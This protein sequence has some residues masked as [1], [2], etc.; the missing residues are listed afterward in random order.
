MPCTLAGLIHRGEVEVVSDPYYAVSERVDLPVWTRPCLSFS[1]TSATV[2]PRSGRQ[3][4]PRAEGL[5][6]ESAF[7][8]NRGFR[9]QSRRL[10]SNG[11]APRRTCAA[12]PGGLEERPLVARC[13]PVE[14]RAVDEKIPVSEP[15]GKR[16]R[17]GHQVVPAPTPPWTIVLGKLR[18]EDVL[19]SLDVRPPSLR[20]PG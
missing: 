14:P 2:R 18:G 6:W 9:R 13:R 17:I 4:R 5:E 19:V 16:D 10:R 8:S 1:V 20:F 3:S 11:T 7:G 12:C 15:H